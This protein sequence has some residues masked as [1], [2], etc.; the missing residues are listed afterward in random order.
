MAAYQVFVGQV[1]GWCTHFAMHHGG[2]IGEE[3][4]IVGAF[5]CAVGEDQCR[6]A[7]TSGTPAALRV[8]GWCGRHIAQIDGIERR[9]IDAQFHGR[10]TKQHRQETV[11]LA[12]FGELG[13]AISQCVLFRIT[14]A[15]THFADFAAVGIDLRRMFARLIVKNMETVGQSARQVAIQIAEILVIHRAALGHTL[16]AAKQHAAGIELPSGEAAEGAGYFEHQPDLRRGQ[17][18]ILQQ[19]AVVLALECCGTGI[20]PPQAGSAQRPTQSALRPGAHDQVFVTEVVLAPVGCLRHQVAR[21]ARALLSTEAPWRAQ[22]IT[23]ACLERFGIGGGKHVGSHCQPLSHD[24]EEFAID[25][26][27]SFRSNVSQQ[28]MA[29]F[30]I[31][32][33]GD[34]LGNPFVVDGQQTELLKVRVGEA[35]PATLIDPDTI[36]QHFPQGALRI[37]ELNARELRIE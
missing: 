6:H 29:A 7:T 2:R 12:D 11:V 32:F 37:D 28:L 13:G 23:R 35:P 1:Q 16:T 19:V 24:I 34:K 27:A 33:I 22:Q 20:V 15:E 14:E 8:V 5:C 17:E 4:L 26:Q 21:G 9:N 18:Q 10:R 36:A 3:V 30:E 25:R 31:G